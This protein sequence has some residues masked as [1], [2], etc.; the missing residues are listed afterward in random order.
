[1]KL[2]VATEFS[3]WPGGRYRRQGPHSA[4][5]LRKLMIGRLADAV[6]A[7]EQLEVDL[8]GSAGYAASFLEEAFGGLVREVGTSGVSLITLKSEEQPEILEEIAQYMA[9][10]AL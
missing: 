8:D 3:R 6:L 10:A 5:E 2:A 7:G 4:E 1:V 9:E